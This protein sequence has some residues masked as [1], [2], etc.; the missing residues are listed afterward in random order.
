MGSTHPTGG[1]MTTSLLKS[2]R[3]PP[4]TYRPKTLAGVLAHLEYE[5]FPEEHVARFQKNYA[6]TAVRA[7]IRKRWNKAFGTTMIIVA[8]C[9]SVPILIHS[10]MVGWWALGICLFSLFIVES[11]YLGDVEYIRQELRWWQT[12]AKPIPSD[13]HKKVQTIRGRLPKTTFYVERFQLDPFLWVQ[14]RNESYCI[15]HWDEPFVDR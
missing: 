14:Y 4:N 10:A 12:P 2:V 5:V 6:T 8:L 13:L 1:Y 15:G 9:G 3:I 11:V 7:A